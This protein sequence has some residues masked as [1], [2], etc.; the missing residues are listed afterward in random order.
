[1][2]AAVAAAGG[3]EP[4]LDGRRTAFQ[5]SMIYVFV[6]GPMVALVAAVPLAWG[7]GV[8]WHDLGLL[9]V[10]Y[11]LAVLGI[12]VGFHRHFTHASF[13]A[14]PW[15]RVTMA[16]AG[17]LAVQGNVLNWVADHRRHHAFSDR[18]GDPHSPWLHGTSPAA[19]AKGFL[20]AHM[21]WFF[22]RDETNHRRFI[23]DL[24]ADRAVMRVS[25]LFGL[26]VA[27][28]LLLPAVLGGLITWSWAGIVTGFFW[29][30][31]VRLAIS[32]H[33]TWSINSIC[34]MVGRRPFRSRDRSRNFW[35][36]A[37][38]S[39]G[40]SWH[41]LHHADPTCARHGVLP[42]QIDI[43]ARLIWIFERFGWAYDVRWPT[44]RRLE[45]L[46]ARG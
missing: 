17:S 36:L 45:K 42:G 6:A 38:L 34:H 35:P 23:P 39:M 3:P 22:D 33:V 4:V 5:H 31:L 24:L 21:T 1:M 30:G 19:V 46:S 43:S 15:L 44:T 13:K 11:T 8:G 27:V 25:R 2:S 9:A 40:E 28:S 29:G 26:W 14:R 12:T 16:I 7:W 10:F 41:N 37:V 20:H 32:N 18:E